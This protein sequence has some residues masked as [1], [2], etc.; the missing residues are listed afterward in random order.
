ME[1]KYIYAIIYILCIL[2][3]LLY[4]YHIYSYI[5]IYICLIH[6]YIYIY[7]HTYA[8]VI[9]NLYI[10]YIYVLYT[11]Y[12]NIYIY[13]VKSALMW[14]WKEFFLLARLCMEFCLFVSDIGLECRAR[15]WFYSGTIAGPCVTWDRVL[16]DSS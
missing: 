16:C 8:Y 6:I 3:V 12:I 5:Y 13:V 2:Y 9:Y 14:K 15:L 7:I 1:H 4:I 11:H 10:S